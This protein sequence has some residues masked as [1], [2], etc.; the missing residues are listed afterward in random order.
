MSPSAT[1]TNENS[2]PTS[3]FTGPTTAVEGVSTQFFF[4]NPFDPSQGDRTAGFLYSVDLNGDGDYVDPGEVLDSSSANVSVTFP[5]NG[6]FAIK[7]RIK[8]RDGGSTL[9]SMNVAAENKAPTARLFQ[10]I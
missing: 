2:N 4:A 1:L 6:L 8:D 7:G 10:A 3:E 9:Y 5:D